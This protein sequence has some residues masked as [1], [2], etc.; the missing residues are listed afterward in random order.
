MSAVKIREAIQKRQ[1]GIEE[2][3]KYYLCRLDKYDGVNGLN[4]V[5]EINENAIL[6]AR[7]MDSSA[8]SESLPLFGLPL[9]VKDNIDVEH[10]H[11]TAGSIALKE[12]LAKQDA[13]VIANLRRNGAIILGKTNMTEF[14]NYVSPDMPNGYSSIGGQVKNA[15]NGGDPSGSSSGSAVAVSARLCAAAIGTDT[16][17]SIVGCATVNG[18]TGYKPPH[19]ALSLSGIVPISK[20]LDSPGPITQ[21]L[22]DAIL[23]YNA[24]RQNRLP[25][26][27]STEPHAIH[28]AINIYNSEM[29]SDAQMAKYNAV[30]EGLLQDGATISE[31]N[32]S[33]CPLQK[34]IMRIEFKSGPE[35]YLS[36]ANTRR[37]TLREIIDCYYEDND[38]MPYG[39]HFLTDALTDTGGKES[40]TN[41]LLEREAVRVQLIKDL[42]RYDACLMT[43]P[44]NI[45]HFSGLP[46]LALRLGMGE[47]NMPRG[48]ILYGADEK[49]LLACALT[50]EKYC[51]GITI[52]ILEES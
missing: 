7:Q 33:Y 41:A 30:I 4:T 35:E 36:H 50:I 3:V 32:H 25:P 48:M 40:Y 52:P 44:T 10:L 16:S 5:R 22:E 43:G 15:Y 51:T 29:V 34:D 14:A 45:M 9:L 8:L 37:S 12:N 17:F 2:L 6:Q 20:M 13:P 18:V 46:A 38:C 19:G 11:T 28:L 31:V 27:M 42:E 1:I 26:I 39:V 21:S 24:M 23:I 49:R 47:D